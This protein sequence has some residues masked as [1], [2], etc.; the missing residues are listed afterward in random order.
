MSFSKNVDKMAVDTNGGKE[1]GMAFSITLYNCSFPYATSLK[2]ALVASSDGRLC[3]ITGKG[4]H[5]LVSFVL[6]CADV[7]KF[8][9]EFRQ[10]HCH[11]HCKMVTLDKT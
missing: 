7:S 2:G 4:V 3:F 8:F 5:I 1:H 10:P 9:F 6:F 11:I